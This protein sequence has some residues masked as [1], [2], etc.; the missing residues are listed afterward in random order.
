MSNP[1]NAILQNA[2][3]LIENNEL[4]DAQNILEP[5]L[6]T[7][8]NNPAVWWVYAHALRDPEEGMKA[9]DRVVQL[10]PTYPGAS[11]LKSQLASVSASIPEPVSDTQLDQ[12][13]EE[14]DES[15]FA[16]PEPELADSITGGRSPIRTLL[17]ALVVI[18][19][20]VGIF[21]VLS[22]VFGGDTAPEPTEVAQQATDMPTA[23]SQVATEVE[24]TDEPAPTDE[25]TV[26]PTEVIPT[27]EPTEV[28]PTD[29]PTEVEPTDEPEPTIEPTEVEPT[30]EPA[31]VYL[32]VLTEN[33]TEY[34]IDEEAIETRETLLGTTLDVTVCAV[35]GAPSSIALN[36][37]MGTLV[38]LN[39]EIPA[40]IVAFAVTLIDC[41]NEVPVPRTIGVERSFVQS[42]ADEEI[43]LK[44]LQRE[45]KP[46][47]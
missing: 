19:I 39:S 32:S 37:V 17:I 47:P 4:E 38:E 10:D 14:W 45:W 29:E 6:E 36:D 25:P 34:E 5:L 18:I 21:A 3:D 9:I 35:A 22:G 33:L 2:F 28:E 46:L 30:D 42:F 26:E 41:N 16:P 27:D 24:P 11:E 43:A 40:D 13:V 23:D 12:P 31:D 44:D 8:S 1:T 15:D 20:V 7:N